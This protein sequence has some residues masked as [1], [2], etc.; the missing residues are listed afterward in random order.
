[1]SPRP[2]HLP[3]EAALDSLRQRAQGAL[4]FWAREWMS[5]RADQQ[6]SA[7]AQVAA[8]DSA[9]DS[10]REYEAMRSKTG[11]MWFRR[12]S[13]DRVNFAREV[14]GPELL[15]KGVATD[16][17]L[18]EIMDRAWHARNRALCTALLGTPTVETEATRLDEPPRDMF[19]FGS[20]AVRLSCDTLGLYAIADQSVWRSVPPTQRARRLPKVTPLDRASL[21]ATVKLE[22]M[23]GSV[24]VDLP[25]I[26]DLRCGDVLRLPERVDQGIA[27]LCDGKPFARAA[28]GES[29]GNKCA[30]LMADY[31]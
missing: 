12:S 22:A 4:D 20:G 6:Q 7:V 31:K 21:Q 3:G 16:D 11:C 1:V 28:L 26:L 23:L 10:T 17:W 27:V 25:K 8:F 13:D 30:Q 9:C 5:R 19:A 15:P 2:I 14:F 18:S 29:R 24:A